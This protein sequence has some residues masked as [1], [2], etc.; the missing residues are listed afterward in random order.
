MWIVG[1]WRWPGKVMGSKKYEVPLMMGWGPIPR[2]V[3]FTY[4]ISEPIT[5]DAGPDD[6]DNP[7]VVDRLHAMLWERGQ[8]MLDDGIR[9]RK[10]LWFG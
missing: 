1:R 10:S 2:P 6:A 5:L 9:R 8:T 3:K 7:E 4:Y